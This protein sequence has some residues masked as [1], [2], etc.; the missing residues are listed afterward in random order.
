MSKI[1]REYGN[2]GYQVRDC[3]KRERWPSPMSNCSLYDLPLRSFSVLSNELPA[4]K[5]AGG[6]LCDACHSPFSSSLY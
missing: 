4:C 3:L 1:K 6:D 5:T 2:A